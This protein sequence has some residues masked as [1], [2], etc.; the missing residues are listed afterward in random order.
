MLVESVILAKVFE[1]EF[2]VKVAKRFVISVLS[3]AA[4]NV[5]IQSLT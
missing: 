3:L 2:G 5:R 1:L 4:R